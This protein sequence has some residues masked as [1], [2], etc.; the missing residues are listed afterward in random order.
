VG[1]T[2]STTVTFSGTPAPATFVDSRTLVVT[3]PTFGSEQF[4][5]VSVTD[6]ANGSDEFYPFIHTGT[7]I[8]VSTTGEDGNNSG[9]DPNAPRLTVQGG[10]NKTDALTPHEIRVEAGLYVEPE[11][12]MFHGNVL[13][14]GW[15]PGFGS[16]DPDAHVTVL[17][18]AKAG[19]TVR[20]Q[21]LAVSAVIDGC[22][23]KNGFRD[24]FGGGGLAISA[25]SLVVNNNVIV[26]NDSST[27]GGGIYWVASTTYGGT[28]TFSNNVLVGN[29]AHN[30]N[31]GGIVIYPNYNTQE[32]V[33]V[34]ITGN[35]IVG[36]RSFKGRGG[37]LSLSTGSYAGY[38]NGSLKIA[39]NTFGYNWAKAGGA[40]AATLL[41][42][43]D[44]YDITMNNN[45]MTGNTAVGS[46]GGVS[47]AGVGQID[48]AMGCNTIADNSGAFGLGGGFVIDG[49]LTVA[50]GYSASDMILWNNFGGDVGGQAYSLLTYSDAGVALPGIGN[51]SSDPAFD[52]GPLGE[53]YL[54]QADPN[55][56]DSPAVDA[57]SGLAS[58]LSVEA[59]T[60][61]ID[62]VTDAGFADM[63]FHY[64]QAD[65]P[66]ANPL[67]ILRVDPSSGDLFG[68]DWVLVRGD[69]FDPG[70][71][72]E[73]A[74]VP[75][76]E[77]I[78]LGNRRLLARPA[79]HPQGFVNVRVRNPDDST[80]DAISAYLYV[81]NEPP[82]WLSTVG[83]T[84][85]TSSQSCVRSVLV[86][87]NDAVDAFSPPVVYEIHRELCTVSYD[88]SIPCANFGFI[89]NATNS[90]G[91]A[92]ASPFLDTGYASGGAD[93]KY[94][95]VVRARDSVHPFND[96][97][98]DLLSD[99]NNPVCTAGDATKVGDPNFVCAV[100]SDC[101]T[102]YPFNKEWNF[103]KRLVLVGTDPNDTTPPPEI[104]D[105]LAWV[106]GDDGVCDTSPPKYDPNNGV[107]IEGDPAKI[108]DPNFV[109]TEHVHCDAIYPSRLDWPAPLDAVE[110]GF[111]Q[112]TAA[113][114]FADPNIAPALV[115][116]STNNDLDGDGVTDS[117]Y[118]DPN[119]PLANQIFYYRLTAIDP[120][121]NETRSE[122]VP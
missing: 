31:G 39:G 60:T 64:T 59:L 76:T 87:W 110:Y 16:R 120:C 68:N 48:G 53:F 46:G 23:V 100:D 2:S 6:P 95:Y 5:T 54:I 47:F 118:I 119:T 55:Q 66:S 75:A 71:S 33:R 99:P 28:P 70:A 81:D 36:N 83:V 8:Y 38:N 88:T 117:E 21:G 27:M 74:G 85:V 14:C 32:E 3:I 56:P 9:T 107:C 77:T 22:T 78:F 45:L 116:N 82:V 12:R 104:G 121:D 106:P 24:G 30:K 114:P 50:A 96:G 111:Y 69:G 20:T 113:T 58:D 101:D 43:G 105:N 102:P 15:A 52:A 13:T 115:L 86:E 92:T 29:R 40:V 25:D 73:F 19:Y 63:G 44:Y 18:A 57:G 80:A 89:P 1:F 98:C 90:I 35:K 11:I 34:N 17:D 10:L 4:S 108:S 26:G 97:I 67:S 61:R 91:T 112:T 103:S 7:V 84:T 41:T 42:F 49:A 51:I 37:G 79:L 109:C 122:L 94:L 65:G 72:V 62:G 93:P